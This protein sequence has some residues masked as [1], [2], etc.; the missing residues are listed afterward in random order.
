[1]S[2]Q[3]PTADKLANE[4]LG[5]SVF[6]R[7]ASPSTST[8]PDAPPVPVTPDTPPVSPESTPADDVTMSRRHSVTTSPPDKLEG[9]DINR[10][11]ASRD[12]LRLA[13]DETKAL[14]GLR[15][16]LKWDYDLT[17]SKNDICRAALHWLLEDVA[18]KGEKSS[19]ISRLKRKITS[20]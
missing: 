7:P 16:S 19:A 17:V 18:A 3:R 5:A 4:L 20:R 10:P 2:K 8:P 6:F 14:D 9:F 15:Q 12:S 13:I 1:M 11:T